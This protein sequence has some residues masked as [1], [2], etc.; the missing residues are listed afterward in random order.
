MYKK[1][2]IA[3]VF[4][5]LLGISSYAGFRNPAQE[6]VDSEELLENLEA[7]SYTEWLVTTACMA[8]VKESTSVFDLAFVV[9]KCL[10]CGDIVWATYA[11]IPGNCYNPLLK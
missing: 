9:R 3:V 4:V 10:P 2:I 11:G 1:Y 7:L 6:P 8:D 5:L